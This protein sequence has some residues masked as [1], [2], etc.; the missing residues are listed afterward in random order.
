[1]QSTFFLMMEA[2]TRSQQTIN[3]MAAGDLATLNEI[4]TFHKSHNALDKY[5]IP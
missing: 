3:I 5:P 1:M 4:D 2:M